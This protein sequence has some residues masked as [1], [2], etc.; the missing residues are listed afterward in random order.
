MAMLSLVRIFATLLAS[1]G[2]PSGIACRKAKVSSLLSE[3]ALCPGLSVT[4][5]S[6]PTLHTGQ[7]DHY[8]GQ[9]SDCGLIACLI[10]VSRVLEEQVDIVWLLQRE[11]FV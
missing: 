6:E 5:P 11:E 2:V 3:T 8:L 7:A 1:P 9:Q 10:C 4:C